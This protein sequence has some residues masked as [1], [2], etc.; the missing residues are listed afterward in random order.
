MPFYYLIGFL[1]MLVVFL[2]PGRLRAFHFA[3][4]ATVL[5]GLYVCSMIGVTNARF[6][7]VYEPFI[8]LYFFLF[9]D[10]TVDFVKN[11]FPHRESA[12]A[13]ST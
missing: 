2:R 12:P 8:L 6:R 10:V 1:G 3:W 7:F 9:F 13:C 11:R 4:V 5:G